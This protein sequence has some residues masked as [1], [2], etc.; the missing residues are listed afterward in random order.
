[1]NKIK[2]Y[3]RT[4]L[5]DKCLLGFEFEFVEDSSIAILAEEGLTLDWDYTI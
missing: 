3:Q 1:M 2:F 5:I 4:N